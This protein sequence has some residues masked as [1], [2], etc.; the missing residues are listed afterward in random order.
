MRATPAGWPTIVIAAVFWSTI[1]SAPSL[2][3]ASGPAEMLWPPMPPNRILSAIAPDVLASSTA[4]AT[5]VNSLLVIGIPQFFEYRSIEIRR[6]VEAPEA[7]TFAGVHD[8]ATP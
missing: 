6:R 1:A 3:D 4:A 5:A 7:M 2:A 8:P